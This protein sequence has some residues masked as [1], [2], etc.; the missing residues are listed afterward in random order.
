MAIPSTYAA[1]APTLPEI[2]GGTLAYMSPEQ[3]GGS[4]ARSGLPR[5][6]LEA[7]TMSRW[8]FPRCRRAEGAG[9][10]A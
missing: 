5:G 6:F 1:M 7:S 3:T 10:G 9:N 8:P 2:L 4:P